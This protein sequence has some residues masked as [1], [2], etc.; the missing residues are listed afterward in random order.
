MDELD[1]EVYALVETN[2]GTFELRE[3][4]IGQHA[5][6]EATLINDE[7]AA[8]VGTRDQI[9]VALETAANDVM[10]QALTVT[11]ND[12]PFPEWEEPSD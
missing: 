6:V 5:G 4:F 10:W 1:A 11:R 7:P 9:L 3:A 12:E 2:P 8:F